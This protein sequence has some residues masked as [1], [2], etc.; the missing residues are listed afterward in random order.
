VT[1]R[2]AVAPRSGSAGR[3]GQFAGAGAAA[4]RTNAPQNTADAVPPQRMPHAPDSPWGRLRGPLGWSL[5]ELA[6]RTGISAGDLS[7]IERGFGPTPDHARRLLE[8]YDE[9]GV[10]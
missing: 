3:I 5:R 1:D 9:A 6:E 8:V 10:R 2:A 7:R 4:L